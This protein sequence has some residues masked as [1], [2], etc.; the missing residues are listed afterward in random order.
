MV[1]VNRIGILIGIAVYIPYLI[2]VLFGKRVRAVRTHPQVRILDFIGKSG[3]L[4]FGLLNFYGY[5]Y[6]FLNQGLE[7]A[8]IIL[9]FLCITVNYVCWLRYYICG[10]QEAFLYKRLAGIPYPLGVSECALYLLS[11]ILLGNP[12]TAVFSVLYGI[13]HIYL[14]IRR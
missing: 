5:G 7:I 11:G 10:R 8:W 4:C 9:F 14:G 12:I 2:Y 6:S 3:V 13:S 1:S